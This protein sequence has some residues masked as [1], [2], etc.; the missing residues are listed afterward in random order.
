MNVKA[1]ESH[2][3]RLPQIQMSDFSEQSFIP[4]ALTN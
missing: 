4:F 3:E 2:P 1:I